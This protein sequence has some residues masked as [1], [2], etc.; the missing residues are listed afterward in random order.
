MDVKLLNLICFIFF[1]EK[2][3]LNINIKIPKRFMLI[4]KKRKESIGK[5]RQ[6]FIVNTC[7]EVVFL[8]HHRLLFSLKCPFSLHLTSILAYRYVN[9]ILILQTQ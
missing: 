7:L 5:K 1:Y 3:N 9:F 8:L 4:L 2:V 6:K